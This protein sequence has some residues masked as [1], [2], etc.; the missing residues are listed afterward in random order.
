MEEKVYQNSKEEIQ[1]LAEAASI[2]FQNKLIRKKQYYHTLR[3]IY[4]KF[5]KGKYDFREI[6]VEITVI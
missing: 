3:S 5:V 1:A 4:L 2:L 6:E